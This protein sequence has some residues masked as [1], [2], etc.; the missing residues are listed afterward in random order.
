MDWGQPLWAGQWDMQTRIPRHRQPS[1][2]IRSW[3]ERTAFAYRVWN[4]ARGNLPFSTR[5]A[6]PADKSSFTA[7]AASP[8]ATAV[9]AS[10]S[11]P[12][13]PASCVHA[14]SQHVLHSCAV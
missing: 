10:V 12:S 11:A 4:P 6:A 9:A 3:C 14:R 7:V 1:K 2:W 5:S 8:V 13:K